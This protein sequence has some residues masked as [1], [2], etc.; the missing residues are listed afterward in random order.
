VSRALLAL[1]LMLIAFPVQ[2]NPIAPAKIVVIDGDT[3]RVGVGSYR[4]IG[5]DTPETS[6]ALC[7]GERA[8]GYA[9]TAALRRL[10]Y[11]G[12]TLNLIEV[13]C[14]CAP[15]TLNTPSCNRGRLC[16]VLTAN[17]V[18]V[19]T[20]KPGMPGLI[21]AARHAARG[22]KDGAE[23]RADLASGVY[24]VRVTGR[25]PVLETS[26]WERGRSD[27]RSWALEGG[28]VNGPLSSSHG[29]GQ[30]QRDQH[31]HGV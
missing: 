4:L 28:R 13:P 23:C 8:K 6:R 18:D 21:T 2:A 10:I 16:G 14:S 15:G 9:A 5:F 19:A 1:L 27:G 24:G 25:G 26:S 7:A 3:I 22:D 11:S 30:W 12:Q 31:R 29:L 17:G 20:S